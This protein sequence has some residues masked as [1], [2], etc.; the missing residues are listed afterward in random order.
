MHYVQNVLYLNY[1]K[2]L[3]TTIVYKSAIIINSKFLSFIIKLYTM[4]T[5][6]GNDLRV[7]KRFIEVYC[8]AHHSKGENS[9]CAECSSLGEY[10]RT[11]LDKCPY[12]PKPK[13]KDCLTHC[14]C[15]VF[16]NVFCK[17]RK[18]RLA[19]Q[20]FSRINKMV[21]NPKGVSVGCLKRLMLRIR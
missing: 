2:N 12:D 16:R 19:D 13:C 21:I 5:R 20:V 9:L 11:R 4:N 14:Y 15:A 8:A 7:L 18:V 10:A 1:I 6:K 17:A 3:I